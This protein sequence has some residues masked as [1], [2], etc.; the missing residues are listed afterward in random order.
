MPVATKRNL[1][2]TIKLQEALPANEKVPTHTIPSLSQSVNLRLHR[3]DL[4]RPVP[5]GSAPSGIPPKASDMLIIMG[6]A[7]VINADI[8]MLLSWRKS[9]QC[10]PLL[11]PTSR[12]GSP[13]KGE[14][15]GIRCHGYNNG[16]RRLIFV[17][18]DSGC[19][20]IKCD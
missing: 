15:G 8:I 20:Y 11:L 4:S 13:P 3:R 17:D 1:R 9:E 14:A 10:R 7:T 5:G 2:G 16:M 6:V 12:V 18:W 19:N